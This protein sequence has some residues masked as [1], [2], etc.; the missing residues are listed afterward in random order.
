M[1]DRSVRLPLVY[2]SYIY[3]RV[4]KRAASFTIQFI[5]NSSTDEFVSR[6]NLVQLC[7]II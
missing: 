3:H 5:G 6:T 1:N 7:F 2:K 4:G